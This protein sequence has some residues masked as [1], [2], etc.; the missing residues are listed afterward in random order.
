MNF[1]TISDD[2]R[3]NLVWNSFLI[4]TGLPEDTKLKRCITFSDNQRESIDMLRS[5]SLGQKD[6][7]LTAF[8]AYKDVVDIPVPG[9]FS[10]VTTA[11]G[12]PYCVILTKSVD[13][14]SFKTIDFENANRFCPTEKLLTWQLKNLPRFKAQ[15][16]KN[17]FSFTYDSPVVF[18]VFELLYWDNFTE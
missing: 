1:V 6:L 11:E 9:D 7:H 16:E 12:F 8:S 18:E 10:I 2:R 15:A 3:I 5:A 13:I 14:V 4:K 17:G